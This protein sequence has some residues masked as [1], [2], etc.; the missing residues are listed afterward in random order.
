MCCLAVF[1]Y[2]KQNKKFCFAPDNQIDISHDE[3]LPENDYYAS[4]KNGGNIS[5]INGYNNE[6]NNQLNRNGNVYAAPNSR[7]Q[8]NGNNNYP[9]NTSRFNNNINFRDQNGMY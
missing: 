2:S 5:T 9:V 6:I 7:F 1:F 4:M 3:K 8:G